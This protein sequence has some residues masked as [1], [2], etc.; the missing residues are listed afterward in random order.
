MPEG[1]SVSVASLGGGLAPLTLLNVVPGTYRV[2]AE[3]PGYDIYEGE[4]LVERPAPG[5]T[6]P[7]V[8]RLPLV[9]STGQLRIVSEPAGLAYVLTGPDGAVRRGRTPALEQQIPVGTWE[10]TVAREGFGDRRGSVLVKRG[11]ESSVQTDLADGRLLIDSDPPG[12]EV[13]SGGQ[14]LGVTPYESAQ[15]RPGRHDLELR[16][17][18]YARAQIN[19]EVLPREA[20]RQTVAL[21]RL[22]H[23][24]AGLNW[25][26]TLGMRF[27]PVSGMTALVAVWET[28]EADYAAFARATNR[29][30]RTGRAADHPAV[31]ISWE[32]ARAFCEW[33]T[34][35]ERREGRLTARQRYRLPT[36]A[37]WSLAVGLANERGGS[38]KEKDGRI[39]DVYPW[40]AAWPPPAG[41]GN[42]SPILGVDEF[43]GLAPVGSFP[44][45]RHGLHDLG[46]NVWEWCEDWYDPAARNA[47]VLRGASF[48]RYAR[49]YL[50]SSYRSFDPPGA[51]DIYTGF[52]CVLDVDAQD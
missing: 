41:A 48:S 3:M 35:Q 14:R 28:R 2:Q 52:R 4:I 25:E 8:V 23:P 15:A 11:E 6:E 18:G 13:W 24:V 38:P 1:A 21:Q 42:Y 47:R 46:G 19:P 10:F 50:L 29:G 30:A 31:E 36:D 7:Q 5:K 39:K 27:A 33:L 40:G 34:A 9:R 43:E 20:T 51:R 22:P 49:D 32:D 17:T 16:L 44:A 37:E 26:N 45:N 12:A